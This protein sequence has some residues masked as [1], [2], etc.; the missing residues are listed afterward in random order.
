ME[1]IE[2]VVACRALRKKGGFGRGRDKRRFAVIRQAIQ[3]WQQKIIHGEAVNP[4]RVGVPRAAVRS[5]AASI[6]KQ[7]T[8]PALS[9]VFGAW[10]QIVVV[11]AV[12]SGGNADLAHVA[13]AGGGLAFAFGAA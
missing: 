8:D 13:H 12:Q 9:L 10:E 7:R 3:S 5:T 2:R 4:V 1:M 6:T 11:A